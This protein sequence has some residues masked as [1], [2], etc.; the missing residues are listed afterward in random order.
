MTAQRK[1]SRELD[2]EIAERVFGYAVK[3]HS[4]TRWWLMPNPDGNAL[5]AVPHY[6][7]DEAAALRVDAKMA[8]LGY[9]GRLNLDDGPDSVPLAICK[10]AL[11]ALDAHTPAPAA[12]PVSQDDT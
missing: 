7:T 3:R 10:A 5:V 12:V 8:E 11:K 9:R 6:S 4:L 1:A 2:A